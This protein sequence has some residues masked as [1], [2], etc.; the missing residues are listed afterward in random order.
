MDLKRDRHYDIDAKIKTSQF[1][2]DEEAQKRTE[3]WEKL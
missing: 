1:I 2:F 3:D